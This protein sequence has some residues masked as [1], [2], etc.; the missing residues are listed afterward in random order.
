MQ[1]QRHNSVWWGLYTLHNVIIHPML[2]L[3][4]FLDGCSSRLP[5]KVS[6]LIHRLHDE[7]Y[8]E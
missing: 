2:P 4:E 1:A 5:R 3:A 7:S 8:P 6:A